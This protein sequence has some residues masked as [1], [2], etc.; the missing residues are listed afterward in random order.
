MPARDWCTDL[1]GETGGSLWLKV[2]QVTA[3]AAAEWIP[4][5]KGRR[6]GQNSGAKAELQKYSNLA[7][8][9]R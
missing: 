5:K 1:L 6:L 2:L 8:K 3:A 7:T 4:A 9:M